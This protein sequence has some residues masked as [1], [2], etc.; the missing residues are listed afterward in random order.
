M[1]RLVSFFVRQTRNLIRRSKP[2]K[3]RTIVSL[4]NDHARRGRVL[5]SYLI[6]AFLLPPGQALPNEHTNYWEALQIAAT[7]LE[8]GY[9]VDVIS[10]RNNLFVPGRRY[11]FFIDIRWNMQRLSGQ[12]NPDCIKIAHLDTAHILFHT[13]AEMNRLLALQR[14]RGVTLLPRRLERPNLGIEH[15]D[16]ATLL[17]ND[18]TA[19]TYA[20][21]HK[22][23]YRIPISTPV[24]YPCPEEKDFD[25][26]RHRFLWLGSR[27]MVHKGLDL[28]LEA[29]TRMPECHLTV[30]G[31]VRDEP[32]FENAYHDELYSSPNIDVHGWTD[33]AGDAFRELVNTSV[34]LV[35]AS[36]SEGQSGAVLSCMHAGLI[37]IV[38][39]ESGVDVDAAFGL[40]LRTSS[41][42][43]I[44]EAVKAI[45]TLPAERLRE[46][47]HAAWIFA[48]THHTRDKFAEV[49]R[50]AIDDIIA[51]TGR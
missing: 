12:L 6:D 37:P 7:F 23:I 39:R 4:E 8:L 49:Y 42:E 29:F 27:G 31:P 40:V 11:D 45:T 5:L 28:L 34:G 51:R 44:C 9:C 17:G 36:C 33:I 47:A 35:Y 41:I 30:C 21:A 24:L 10:H 3:Y 19:S 13:T 14:R 20:Y 25:A 46:M 43:E 26:C 18:F 2:D 15:A 50:S 32:D 48:R 38:S 1:S 16:F 22:P